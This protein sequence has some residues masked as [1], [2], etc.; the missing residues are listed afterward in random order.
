MAGVSA[1]VTPFMAAL[2]R[3]VAEECIPAP[4][5]GSTT[6]EL[7]GVTRSEDS[8]VL[9]AASMEAVAF[10]A[11]GASMGVGATDRLQEVNES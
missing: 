8:P 4:S 3:T 11:V 2:R 10:M 1:G 6:E 9:A 7:P 5:V